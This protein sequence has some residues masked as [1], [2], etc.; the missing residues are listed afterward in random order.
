M[1]GCKILRALE[2]IP[3]SLFKSRKE[4]RD[5]KKRL[6]TV[7]G[8]EVCEVFGSEYVRIRAPADLAGRVLPADLHFYCRRNNTCF[9]VK[10]WHRE[11]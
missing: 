5:G 1:I 11:S 7:Q 4:T 9:F 2:T 3:I 6:K 10:S 8:C